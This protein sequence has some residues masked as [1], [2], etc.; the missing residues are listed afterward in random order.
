MWSQASRKAS[1][2]RHD[3]V[4]QVK[5]IRK[6]RAGSRAHAQTPRVGLAIGVPDGSVVERNKE[7]GEKGVK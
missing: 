5:K 3:R 6:S 4:C 2:Q 7:N 1:W